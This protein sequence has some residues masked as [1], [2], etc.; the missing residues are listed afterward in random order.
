MEVMEWKWVDYVIKGEG[1]KSFPHLCE[2]IRNKG[3]NAQLS[4]IP[5]LYFRNNNKTVHNPGTGYLTPGEL[6]ALPLPAYHLLDLE[7]IFS[8]IRHGIFRHGKRVL[9]YM[10]SRGCNSSC[11]FCCRFLGRTFRHKKLS[12]IIDEITRIK[13]IHDVDEIYFEDDNISTDPAFFTQLLQTLT[14]LNLGINMKCANGLRADTINDDILKIMKKAGNYWIGFGI[15]SGSPKVLQLMKKGLDLN[16]T[17]DT[18]KKAKNLGF[19]V[20]SNMIIGYPGETEQDIIESYDYFDKLKLDSLAIVNLIPFPKTAVRKICE[21]KGYLNKAAQDWNNYI[22]DI[23]NPRFL[24]ETEY[25]D[26]PALQRIY[27]KLYLKTYLKPSRM[28][29]LLRHMKLGDV[30]EGSK[31][32]GRKL[33]GYESTAK[34]PSSDVTPA[35]HREYEYETD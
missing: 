34:Q 2:W 12:T 8:T 26:L 24:V 13:K 22:F 6:D 17:S 4:K 16:K 5:G 18:I 21:K 1:E 23:K 32:M 33:L 28:L 3:T 35:L 27:R 14:K 25:L 19:L 10:A 30:W 29:T 9:P 15:E 31:T 7:T 11:T 20:G